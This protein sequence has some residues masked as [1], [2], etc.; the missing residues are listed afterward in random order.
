MDIE[1]I[2]IAAINPGFALI[3]M[4]FAGV[5]S[6]LSMR[7]NS[8]MDDAKVVQDATHDLV[9]HN[10]GVQLKLV[11][12]LSRRIAEL[13]KTPSDIAVA[14]EA[15]RIYQ[16]HVRKQNFLDAQHFSTGTDIP[17]SES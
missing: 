12:D 8:K 11:S 14:T 16:D 9:N 1:K 5:M 15:L 6:Y 4:M 3:G 13:T 2:I 17:R 10:L 7:I